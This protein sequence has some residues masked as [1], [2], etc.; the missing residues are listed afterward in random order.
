VRRAIDLPRDEGWRALQI[1]IFS[2][3]NARGSAARRSAWAY[4]N[5]IYIMRRYVSCV[6]EA[7]GS[8]LFTLF[9]NTRI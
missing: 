2:M 5:I 7:V 4:L 9:S 8:V 6:L 3:T 1:S